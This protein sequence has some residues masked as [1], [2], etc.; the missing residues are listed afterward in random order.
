MIQGFDYSHYN[1]VDWQTANNGLAMDFA[2]SKVTQGI[3]YIDLTFSAQRDKQRAAGVLWGG[4]HF[5]DDGDPNAEADHFLAALGSLQTYEFVILDF[6]VSGALNPGDWCQQFASHVYA[7]LGI[8]P[9]IYAPRALMAE[10]YSY[11]PDCG[12]WLAD[13]DDAV[14][15]SATYNGVRVPY[16]YVMQQHSTVALPNGTAVDSDTFFGTLEQLKKYGAQPDPV[17]IEVP[18]VTPDPLSEPV[19]TPPTTPEQIVTT[20]TDTSSTSTT[21]EPSTPESVAVVTTPVVTGKAVDVVLPTRMRVTAVKRVE[22]EE[23]AVE[24]VIVRFFKWFV[25]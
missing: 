11:V 4:Y 7:K 13:P 19:S 2:I 20:E 25:S 16:T 5:A 24:S 3:S 8:W 6:E 22:E 1:N 10:I 12:L 15:S 23:Q 21:V 18:V 9:I 14:S 17:V